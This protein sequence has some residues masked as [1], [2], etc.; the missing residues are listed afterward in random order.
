MKV[1]PTAISY[2]GL[3]T[4]KN[5]G[6]RAWHL[7]YEKR[8][9]ADIYKG[10]F[11]LGDIMDDVFGK[12]AVDKDL[13]AAK[14]LF[15]KRFNKYDTYLGKLDVLK[16]KK[17]QW[18]KTEGNPEDWLKGKAD[19]AIEAYFYQVVPHIKEVL[20]TQ[21]YIK[22]ENEHGD[23]IRGY[24][25]KIIIWKLDEE[26]NKF[27]NEKGE[28]AFY[29]DPGL[30]AWNDK[31]IL[32]DDKFSTM[33]YTVPDS[34]QLATYKEAP[35]IEWEI[36]GEAYFVVPKKFR[37]RKMP[38]VPVKITIDKVDDSVVESVFEDYADTI[39][40]IKLGQYECNGQG[41]GKPFSCIYKNYCKSGGTDTKGL[42]F[43][44]PSK[45]R[46]R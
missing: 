36:E 45:E 6:G 19:Q 16:S 14:A 35:N 2:S 31:V 3:N 25:D 32:V 30:S 7:H 38:Y 18:S 22:I 11:I 27:T 10:A 39:E 33:K 9:R 42:V 40:K 12:L 43:V 26:A 8:L 5:S 24:A 23:F 46:K 37:T 20:A 44:P 17:I 34:E 1:K 21:Q 28:E 41:C 4:F 29:H 13:D 15:K